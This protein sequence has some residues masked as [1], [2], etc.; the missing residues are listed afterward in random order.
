MNGLCRLCQEERDL[1]ESH[2][3]PRSYY[4]SVKGGKG[5]L[6]KIKDD[7]ETAPA[8]VNADPKELLLCHECEQF[9]SGTYEKEG[10]RLF[11]PSKARRHKIVR[12]GEYVKFK[13]FKYRSTYLYFISI[14]WRV[15][16]SSLPQYSSI[17]LGE[18]EPLVRA[19][20]RQKRLTINSQVR[21]DDF[22]RLGIFRMV[23]RTGKIPDEALKKIIVDFGCSCGSSVE[24]GVVFFLMVDGFLV[25]YLF[26]IESSWELQCASRMLCQIKD[27]SSIKV[28]YM[29]IKEVSEISGVIASAIRKAKIHPY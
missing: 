18:V 3:I 2:I 5:Q 19:C 22:I 20:I 13:G 10:T 14:L 8:F 29:D 15:S 25:V 26:K 7:P 12:M 23:D 1:Q 4:R 21:L 6:V 11:K 28:P 24:E 16:V 27:R 9:L 17:Y